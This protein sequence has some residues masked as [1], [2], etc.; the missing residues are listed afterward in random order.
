[1]A[2]PIRVN[3]SNKM[4]SGMAM[5]QRKHPTLDMI[6]ADASVVCVYRFMKKKK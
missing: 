1:M 3:L 5:L 6:V 2:T 4:E